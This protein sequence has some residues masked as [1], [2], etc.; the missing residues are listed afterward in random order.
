MISIRKLLWRNFPSAFIALKNTSVFPY[1]LINIL[2]LQFHHHIRTIVSMQSIFL[3]RQLKKHFGSPRNRLKTISTLATVAFFCVLGAVIFVGLLFAWYAKDLPRPDKVNR[4][5]GLST[6]ILDR[7]GETVYDIY[8]NQNRIPVKFEDMPKALKDATIAVED[9][10]FYKHKG[11]ST[12]GLV[13]AIINIF[14]FRNLQGGST[15]T[16][17]LVKNAL[18]SQEQ[19]L[20]RKMKEAVLAI[21]IERK[22]KKDEILQMYLNEIPYG[23]TAAGVEAAAKYYFDKHVRELTVPECVILAGLPQAPSLYSPFGKD[24]KAY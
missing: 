3:E 23:G 16:Q 2:F 22:Y 6:V 10:D 7:T 15:L 14:I 18:L 8:E 11:L 21:Q 20:P 24:P 4:V 13:R 19:T 12:T 9:K 1:W 5:E 17:Q